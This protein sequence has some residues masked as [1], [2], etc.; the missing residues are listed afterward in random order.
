VAPILS[1]LRRADKPG[2]TTARFHLANSPLATAL[3]LIDHTNDAVAARMGQDLRR[4]LLESGYGATINAW[5]RKLAA[6]CDTRDLSRLQQ[7][8]ELEVSDVCR[9][10]V[11]QVNRGVAP[12]QRDDHIVAL[13]G[14][15]ILIPVAGVVP[16]AA[17]A[18]AIGPGRGIGGGGW[19]EES[20]GERWG[21]M[22][23]RWAVSSG[24][25]R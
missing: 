5:A 21:R 15:R 24:R 25:W 17:V 14:H 20:G 2:D 19:V 8:V 12:G 23:W 10:A 16:V 1:L 22:R 11:A 13:G 4:Q 18:P 3:E 6:S 9:H 7:L